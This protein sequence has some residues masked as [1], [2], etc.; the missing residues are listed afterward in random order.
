MQTEK[1]IAVLLGNKCN[2]LF[3]RLSPCF[4]ATIVDVCGL[5]FKIKVH[6]HIL[7]KGVFWHSS[8]AE[9]LNDFFLHMF[10]YPLVYSHDCR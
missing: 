1:Q 9:K 7:I 5:Y 6:L 2:F 4:K 8:K 3:L 10:L